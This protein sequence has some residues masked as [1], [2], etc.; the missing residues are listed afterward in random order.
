MFERLDPRSPTPLYAQIAER[1]K[2]AIASG[3][4]APG[5]AL[6]SVRALAARIRVNPATVVQAYRDLEAEGFVEM[7]QGSGTYVKAVSTERRGRQREAQARQLIR[8]MLAEA[9]RLGVQP[10]EIRAALH[11]ELKETR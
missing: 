3:D 5:A 1:L 7:R 6:E 11:D 10:A 4:L 8:Q 9:A 2:V